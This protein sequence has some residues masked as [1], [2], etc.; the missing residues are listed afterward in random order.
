[1]CRVF[2]DNGYKIEMLEER[3]GISSPDVNI[4]GKLADLKSTKGAGN[5]VKYAH[6]AIK[7]QQAEILLFE[8]EQQSIE[9]EKELDKL[10]R[11]GING[12]YY[13]KEEKKVHK[14]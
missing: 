5:I 3:A 7:K 4:N 11:K 12:F 14:L 9:V 10:R 6:K 2:A 13:Y 8:F 1:M